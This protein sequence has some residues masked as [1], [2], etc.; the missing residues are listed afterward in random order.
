MMLPNSIKRLLI[1]TYTHDEGTYIEGEFDPLRRLGR[2]SE[3]I[4]ATTRVI[5][6]LMEDGAMGQVRFS[7]MRVKLLNS[8]QLGSRMS[9][10]AFRLHFQRVF[11]RL[12]YCGP[13]KRRN[14]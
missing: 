7:R 12:F 6:A 8:D 4:F 2:A 13:Y 14:K 3:V 9:A 5:R 10:G 1:C 11:N